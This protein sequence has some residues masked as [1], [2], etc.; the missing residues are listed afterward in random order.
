MLHISSQNFYIGEECNMCDVSAMMPFECGIYGKNDR[1][2]GPRS[3]C[4]VN[5]YFVFFVFVIF[6]FLHIR[7]LWGVTSTSSSSC[8][9]SMQSSRL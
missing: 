2:G 8:M 5:L 3:L 4:C 7:M 1:P 9:Y 6:G